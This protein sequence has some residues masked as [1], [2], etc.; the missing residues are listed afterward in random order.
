MVG[1]IRVEM[2]RVSLEGVRLS[3]RK[4]RLKL[5]NL[6]TSHRVKAE[7]AYLLKTTVRLPQR[8]TRFSI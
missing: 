2:Q 8:K 3:R 5:R 4:H 1:G 6:Q 7:T